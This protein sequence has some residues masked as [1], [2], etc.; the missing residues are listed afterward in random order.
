MES[1]SSTSAPTPLFEAS[2]VEP[3][4]FGSL[5]RIVKIPSVQ[6]VILTITEEGIRLQS[7]RA[8]LSQVCAFINK[9][10]FLTY[11]LNIQNEQAELKIAVPRMQ[12]EKVLNLYSEDVNQIDSSFF[13]DEEC[14]PYGIITWTF[15]CQTA[16]EMSVKVE[17]E[18]DFH[19]TYPLEVIL[20][21]PLEVFAPDEQ[22]LAMEMKMQGSKFKT[23]FKNVL[24]CKKTFQ[25]QSST[26]DILA[27]V[28]RAHQPEYYGFKCEISRSNVIYSSP[29]FPEFNFWYYGKY[30]T[31]D[32]YNSIRDEGNVKVK[33]YNDGMLHI[34]NMKVKDMTYGFKLELV[35]Y[36]AISDIDSEMLHVS[37]D[38]LAFKQRNLNEMVIA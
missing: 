27:I 8:Q 34:Q 36:P 26:R 24:K 11:D 15:L 3:K 20:A 12:L 38:N 18:N 37:I 35:I 21:N 33:V 17:R 31:L 23:L 6:E 28:S 9:R 2:L 19:S 29:E 32:F 16:N 30:L 13:R 4:L 14:I 5:A 7:G 1:E 10:S 22:S 25:F